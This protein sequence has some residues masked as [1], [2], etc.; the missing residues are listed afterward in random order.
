MLSHLAKELQSYYKKDKNRL[1]FSNNL[2]LNQLAIEMWERLN[3]SEIDASVL[4]RVIHGERLFSPK[5]LEVFCEVVKTTEIQ[6]DKL[7]NA[8]WEDYYVKHGINQNRS[9]SPYFI[10][11]AEQ[12]LEIAR[13]AHLSGQ[14]IFALES[15]EIF[16]SKLNSIFIENNSLKYKPELIDL[17]TRLLF[18][19][20][21]CYTVSVSSYEIIKYLKPI[22]CSL[23]RLARIVDNKETLGLSLLILSDAY[24]INNQFNQSILRARQSLNYLKDHNRRI[25]VLRIML[26]CAAYSVETHFFNKIVNET[27]QELEVGQD[28][29]L[30]TRAHLYEGLGRAK[31]LLKYQDAFN[32]LDMSTNYFSQMKKQEKNMYFHEIQIIRSRLETAQ[33]LG[34]KEKNY[35]EK[36]GKKGLELATTYGYKRHARKIKKIL[37]ANL[38]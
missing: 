36:I 18:A 29:S 30:H 15:I 38:N 9:F 26:L 6:R 20:S 28:I 3:Y 32:Y 23:Q 25:N 7:R 14:P 2:S 35:M 31:G 27:K 33:A 37:M 16:L 5:Q 4:S 24:Y 10:E 21:N 17:M 13:K 12:H 22:V 1:L 34:I 11:T 8:L 19:K